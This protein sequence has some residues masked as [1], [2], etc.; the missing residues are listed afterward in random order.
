MSDIKKD[1]IGQIIEIEGG[2]VNDPDDSGGE[3]KYGI[4]KRVAVANGYTGDMKDLPYDLAFE[5]YE[6]RY[7]NRMKLD[8][9]S[10][11]SEEVAMELADTAINMGVTRAGK[12]LQRSLNALNNRERHYAD[13]IVDGRIGMATLTAFDMYRDVR[14]QQGMKV[15]TNMLNCLQGEFYVS[16][17]ERR[18]KDEKYIYGW[19][20]H[21]IGIT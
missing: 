7:W 2:Y 15:L 20:L 1:V 13:L 17:A 4:T 16:L 6:E 9:I 18:Q 10:A 3:T 19:F 11:A 8:P 14:G 12:F 5:I 21:R